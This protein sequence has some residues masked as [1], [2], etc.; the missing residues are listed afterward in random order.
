M[1]SLL[2]RPTGFPARIAAWVASS[3]ATPTM[4]D[5]TK[6][7]SGSVEQAIVPSVPCTVSIPLTPALPQPRGQLGGQLFRGQ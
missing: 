5:T 4:A 1:H 6:S 3:P 2:A 7:A